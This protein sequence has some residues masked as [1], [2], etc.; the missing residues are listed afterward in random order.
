MSKNNIMTVSELSVLI[1]D[2]LDD[3]KELSSLWIRGE[4]SNFKKHA[5]GHLYFSLKDDKSSIRSVMFKSRTWSLNF[6][7]RD[8]MDC[9]VRGYVSV[10]PRDISVQLYVEEILPAVDEKKEYTVIIDIGESHTKVGFAG[11][12]PIVFPTI[13]GKPKYKNL[14]QDVAGSV[15]EAYVGTDADNMRGVLKIEYPISR[16]AVYN[17][18]D[19]FL[20]LSNIFNNILRV[21]SS[22]CHVIYV[23]HPLTPYDTARYYAD[24]LFTTHRVKSV[25]VVNSVALSCFSAGTTTGLTVEIG[26][27]LTFIAPIMN[28]QLY[29]PSIIKL[30]LGNVDINEYMKTL[31]S[32]YGVFLNYSGQREILRQI[33]ENHC[34]VS[35]NLAQDA[36]GQTVTEYNLPDGDSI[37][38]ND[39]ERYNAPEVLFNPSLLGYQFAGIPDS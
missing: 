33:R 31:F 26:E 38:I 4:I 13:V 37:Q 25:L 11:E 18:E 34:K 20:L 23:V 21:D 29:D 19:Y 1:K 35:L 22:K 6:L 10:Y 12:E 36:V 7:P 30:P 9:L 28:G 5:A 15:K 14:M 24:V 2:T 27:G 32:H 16:G 3:K 39:Y 17:W 8:G